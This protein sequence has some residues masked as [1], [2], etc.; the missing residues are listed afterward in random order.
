VTRVPF[1]SVPFLL[2][3]STRKKPP[4][5]L[6]ISAWWRDSHWSGRNTSFSRER[7][8]VMRSLSSL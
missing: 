4:S 8:I 1:S 2:P 5:F 3:R 6:R 7:P